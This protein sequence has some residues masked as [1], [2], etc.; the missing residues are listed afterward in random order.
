MTTSFVC[1]ETQMLRENF[2]HEKRHTSTR[3]MDLHKLII[4]EIIS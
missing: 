1:S 3:A 4:L 2:V